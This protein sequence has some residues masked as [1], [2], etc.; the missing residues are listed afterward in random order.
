MRLKPFS[1]LRNH[2]SNLKMPLPEEA[3]K[4]RDPTRHYNQRANQKLK[5][6][7]EEK[8]T[9]IKCQNYTK[10]PNLRSDFMAIKTRTDVSFEYSAPDSEST[11]ILP[12]RYNC[13][14]PKIPRKF[15]YQKDLEMSKAYEEDTKH[16]NKDAT[17]LLPR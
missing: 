9:I 1:Q 3:K 7:Q 10:Y 5:G 15:Y 14:K 11:D 2:R 6:T 16:S 17:M 13:Y 8:G 12:R 4:I